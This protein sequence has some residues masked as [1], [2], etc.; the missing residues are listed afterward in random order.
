VCS[1]SWFKPV[2]ASNATEYNVIMK[3]FCLKKKTVTLGEVGKSG[4]M[5]FG[6]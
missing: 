5:Y 4:D 1:S 6:D 2:S 3:Y